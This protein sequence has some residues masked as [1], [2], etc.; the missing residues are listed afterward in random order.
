[1]KDGNSEYDRRAIAE[2]HQWKTPELSW[3]GQAM[4]TIDWP[5]SKATDLIME[6]HLIGEAIKAAISGVMSV[7]NDCA[8][9]SVRQDAIYDEFRQAGHPVE[10]P[11]DVTSLRLEEIDKIVG[12]LAAKYKGFAGVEGAA[13]GLIGLP[14]IIADIPAL[15]TVNLR[16][17]GEYATYYGFDV[18]VQQERLF[19]MNVLGLAS[20]PKDAAKHVAMAELVKISRAVAMRKTWATLEEHAFVQLI[21]Q[22][23]RAVGIRMTKAK[24]AQVVPAVGAAVGLGFNAYFTA[25]V[26]DAAYYLY[27][28]RFLAEQYGPDVIE[29]TVEPP[30]DVM[31]HY[32]ETDEAIPGDGCDR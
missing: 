13:A 17:I 23:A 19:A 1:M 25:R 12:F 2:I 28:E 10:T 7:C 18:A 26:C 16:A 29:V 32:D 21:Q 30:H 3:F 11:A 22:I 5:L 14:G 4:R 31:V 8:Q 6:H 15:V 27:R 9:W 20:S 24:L